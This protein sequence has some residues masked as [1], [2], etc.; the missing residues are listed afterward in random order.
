MPVD[1]E[2]GEGPQQP[3][4]RTAVEGEHRP[5]QACPALHVEDLQRLT[6]LPVRDVVMLGPPGVGPTLV[7]PG[8]PAAEFHVVGLARPVRR[9]V[10]RQV[11]KIE[12][13]RADLL[14]QDIGLRRG[15]A[16]LCAEFAARAR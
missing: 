4:T 10:C 11:G 3:G 16:L 8:P 13:P 12:Q 2:R 7:L 9:V 1:G 14:R 15:D 6:D 5:G